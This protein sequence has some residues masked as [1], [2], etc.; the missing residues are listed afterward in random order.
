MTC[1]KISKILGYF[2]FG[3]WIVELKLNYLQFA[4]LCSNFLGMATLISIRSLR[5]TLSKTISNK[6]YFIGPFALKFLSK[7]FTQVKQNA[8]YPSSFY[9]NQGYFLNHILSLMLCN[10][11]TLRGLGNWNF[12]VDLDTL[13]WAVL[14]LSQ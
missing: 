13:S 5:L 4:E 14:N 3:A 7:A 11:L 8:V 1:L 12:A 6:A 10:D 2:D 9:W